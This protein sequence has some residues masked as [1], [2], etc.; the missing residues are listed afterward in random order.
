M[1][2][3]LFRGQTRR[4]GEK[5]YMDGSPVPSNWVYGGVAQSIPDRDFSIIYQV[6]PEIHKFP[7]YADTIGQYTGL[8]DK[9]GNKIFEGDI[10]KFKDEIWESSYTSCG[11]EYDSWE[12]ENYAVVGYSE[13]TARF[14]FVKY[15]FYENS[16]EADLHE[17]H[18]L[19][20]ADFVSEL[21]IVG[22]I[23]DNPE[24]L[25]GE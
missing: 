15:K 20:F 9:N 19:E 22:N 21:E 4:K 23:H 6:E 8:T 25:K 5:V 11:T 1:R 10:F 3:I 12:V 14:D 7:V 24:L 16:V 18:D 13:E 2:E 17:N